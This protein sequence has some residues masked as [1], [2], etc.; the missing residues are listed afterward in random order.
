MTFSAG[1]KVTA[2]KLNLELLDGQVIARG[3]RTTTSTGTSGTTELGVIRL[4]DVPITSGR[5]YT[6]TWRGDPDSTIDT[7]VISVRCRYTTDGSTPSTSSTILPG[8][9]RRQPAFA[10]VT[11]GQQ[12]SALYIPSSNETF[13]VL[14]TQRRVSGTGS[15]TLFANGTDFITDI[16]ITDGGVDPGDTGVDI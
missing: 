15:V 1:E 12:H 8:S 7:D 16:W 3:R 6:I 13:S 2:T 5:L 9:E 11:N 14:L 10:S 4:D